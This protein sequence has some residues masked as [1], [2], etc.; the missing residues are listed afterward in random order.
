MLLEVDPQTLLKTGFTNVS[1]LKKLIART[2]RSKP[3]NKTKQNYT[4]KTLV[5]LKKILLSI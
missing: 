1:K 5:N 4:K 3:L 2:V